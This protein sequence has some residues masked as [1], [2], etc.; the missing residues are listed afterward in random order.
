MSIQFAFSIIGQA[1][2]SCSRDKT[3][4]VWDVATGGRK[5][6]L[7][8]HDDGIEMVAV[9][10]DDKLVATA[11][12]D[13]IVRLWDAETGHE[14]AVLT[15]VESSIFA[16]AFSPERP[17][18][19]HGR[20]QRPGP[21]LGCGDPAIGARITRPP[22]DCVGR[23]LFSRW[24]AAGQ[25]QFRQ[26]CHAMGRSQRHQQSHARHRSATVATGIGPRIDPAGHFVAIAT[27]DRAVQVRDALTGNL[28]RLMGEP[29]DGVNCLA[30]T[31]D[32]QTVAGGGNDGKIRL[33]DVAS[34]KVRRTLPWHQ[35]AVHAVTFS[36]N[37]IHLASAGDDKM[38]RIW[39]MKTEQEVAMLNGH[40]SAV[41]AAGICAGGQTWRAAGPTRRS[42]SGIS[43]KSRHQTP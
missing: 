19:G 35:G 9:A 7:Q 13:Q 36:P 28:V 1:V 10:P 14:I 18:P 33:W 8:G 42:Y 12:W 40:E 31:P 39:D 24:E 6:T 30:F 43:P 34:G 11:G 5:A 2:V 21:S 41:F 32:G 29:S 15:G 3:A 27:K 26:D 4:I 22:S 38:V 17:I 20:R 23:R 37:G 25:R 16:V